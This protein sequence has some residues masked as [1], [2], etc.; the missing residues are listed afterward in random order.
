MFKR[1][2]GSIPMTHKTYIAMATAFALALG[3]LSSAMAEEAP[4]DD[5]A[6]TA[7]EAPAEP[8]SDAPDKA[9]E[10]TEDKG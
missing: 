4:M 9:A 6:D 7:T 3:S 5:K 10:S 8:A 2:E 1:N